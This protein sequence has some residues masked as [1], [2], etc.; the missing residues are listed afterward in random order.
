MESLNTDLSPNKSYTKPADVE[1]PEADKELPRPDLYD[2]YVQENLYSEIFNPVEKDVELGP[3]FP[4]CVL[5]HGDDDPDVP[6]SVS[7]AFVQEVGPENATLVVAPGKAHCFD[8]GFFIDD[9]GV[10]MQAVRKA[11]EL[12]D[13]IVQDTEGQGIQDFVK[14]WT[15]RKTSGIR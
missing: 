6:L 5:L 8:N 9:E 15:P 12:L 13:G 1:D 10:E 7:E 14:G 4:K 11:W 2:Y 3:N